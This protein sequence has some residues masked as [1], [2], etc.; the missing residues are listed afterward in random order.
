MAIIL[1]KPGIIRQAK[2]KELARAGYIVLELETFSDV[3][4]LDETGTIE[5]DSILACALESLG[6]G[7]DTT[8]R[9]RFGERIRGMLLGKL[10]KPSQSP[11]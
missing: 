1:I 9:N 2:R 4:V 3:S 6:W 8:C 5:P 11:A 10:K 7:N